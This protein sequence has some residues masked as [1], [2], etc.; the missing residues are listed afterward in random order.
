MVSGRDV[1]AFVAQIRFDLETYYSLGFDPGEKGD[2]APHEIRV[3]VKGR[4]L[5]VRHRASFMPRTFD[6]RL[7]DRTVG[8]LVLGYT[9]NPHKLEAALENAEKDA[10]GTFQVSVIVQLPIERLG[11][12]ADGGTH[13]ARAR[14]AVVLMNPQG[15]ISPVQHLQVPLRIPEADLAAAKEQLFAARVGLRTTAGAQRVAVGLWDEL[16]GNGSFITTDLEVGVGDGA[17]E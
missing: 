13:T 7:A 8:A 6:D 14:M 5:R 3:K 9:V 17:G 2:T 16:E 15:M 4:D 1:A 11:L 12:V 10:D